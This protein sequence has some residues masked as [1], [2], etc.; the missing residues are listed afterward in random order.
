MLENNVAGYQEHVLVLER[1]IAK[2]GQMDVL[3]RHPSKSSLEIVA[4]AGCS[5]RC[6]P[7]ADRAIGGVARMLARPGQRGAFSYSLQ[8]PLL[9]KD[10]QTPNKLMALKHIGFRWSC[11]SSSKY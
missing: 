4:R 9:V 10:I 5:P 8:V 1:W 11:S 3:P 6:G 2:T 7:C